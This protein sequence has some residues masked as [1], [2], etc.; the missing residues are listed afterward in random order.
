MPVC[1]Y[2]FIRYVHVVAKWPFSLVVSICS[3]ISVDTGSCH[4]TDYREM[5]YWE[6]FMKMCRE[7][8][9]WLKSGKISGHFTRNTFYCC[10][11]HYIAINYS[12]VS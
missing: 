9:V 5:S 12:V 3:S 11:R 2:N 6:I 7:S 8:Q 10:R 1:W 4:W